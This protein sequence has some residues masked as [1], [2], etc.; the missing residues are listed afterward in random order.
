[1][2]KVFASLLASVAVVAICLCL[3]AC[4]SSPVGNYKFSEMS[5]GDVVFKPGE[6]MNGLI[7]IKEDN[8]LSFK[9]NVAGEVE[10]EVG[11][12]ET[13]GGKHYL[14]IDG[15]EQEVTLSGGYL[16]MSGSFGGLEITIKLQKV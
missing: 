2:K 4:A 15:D 6:T 7:E 13:R 14:V 5:M 8:T 9:T 11:T 12:W 3:A 16:V 10:T 1:M